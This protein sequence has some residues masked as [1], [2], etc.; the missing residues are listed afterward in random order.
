[1]LDR[2]RDKE[3]TIRCQAIVALY[4]LQSPDSEENEHGES[5]MEVIL[6]ALEHDP[7]A[8]VALRRGGKASL[9]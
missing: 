2:A 6:D 3:A 9:V 7:S 5:P 4:R 1:M 8:C